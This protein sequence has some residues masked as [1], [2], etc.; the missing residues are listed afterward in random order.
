MEKTKTI[1]HILDAFAQDL[2]TGSKIIPAGSGELLFDEEAAAGKAKTK[3]T[4]STEAAETDP[5]KLRM[6]IFLFGTTAE[7]TSVRARIHGFQPFFFVRLPDSSAKTRSIFKNKLDSALEYKRK[8]L[9][10]VT[11]VT[12]EDRK[13][14][15]GYTGGKSFP[16]AR[17]TVPSMT[18]FRAL[19][20][21]FLT[22]DTS[23]PTFR[24]YADEDAL[25][26]Y[27]A[28]LDPMLRFFHLRNIKPCGWVETEIE[29]EEGG[30]DD[31]SMEWTEL[32][33]CNAPPMAAAPFLM[34]AWDIECYSE[35]GEF[36]LAKKGYDRLAKQIFAL[37]TDAG[38][39]AELILGAA[40]DPDSPP[41]GMDGLRHREGLKPEKLKMALESEVLQQQLEPLL[42]KREGLVGPAKEDRIQKI[43]G[44]LGG[45]LRTALPL[46]GD[47]VIQIGVVLVKG[48]AATEKHI[49]VLGT[50]DKVPGAIVHSY[51]TETKL[52]LGWAE[53]M[54]RWNPDILMGYNVFGFDEKYLWERATE[55]RIAESEQ[56]Q[57][58]S[59]LVDMEKKMTLETKFLSSSALGDNTMWMWSAFG[60]LQVDLFHYIKRSFSLPAY[61]LDYVCQHFMSGKLGGVDLSPGPA[62]Q[63]L[64]K[65]KTTGDAV[66]GR[67]VT[68]LDET[69]DAVVEKL[70]ICDI[71][72]KE[73]LVVEEPTGLEEDV[74]A[75][76][77][78]ALPD[79]VKWAVVKDDVSP[80]DIFRLHREG[81]PAGRAK[82]AA[83]C[84][85][86]CDLTV[87]LY[88]KLDVFNNAMA[89]ANACSVPVPYI[90]TRGQGIKIES[91]IFKECYEREQCVVVLPTQP[92]PV[93]G[94]E[95]EEEE[96]AAAQEES[97]EG[98]IVLTP[99]PGFYFK[100]PIGVADFASLYPSTIISENIS[101]DTLLWAKDYDL[102][103]RFIGYSYGSEGAGA[104]AVAWTDIEFDIWGNKEGDTRKHPEKVKKGL[105]VCRY[106]Q[107]VGDAKGTLPDIVQKL[108]AARKAKRKE[109]ERET[110][111]FKKA[112]LDAEQLAYKLTANSLYGQ[113]GSATFKIRL[114]HLAA[115]VTAYGRKQ[116]L[117]AKAAI[118]KFYGE[119]S[120]R[121]DC[122]AMT[123]YGDTDSLF[124]TFN[125][126]NPTTGELLTGRE[127]IVETMRL[128]EEAG[129][130]VT[131]CLKP[132]HDFEYDKVFAPFIIFSKKRYVGNKYEESPD[133]YYQNSMGIATKRR[134]YAGIV[135]VI[136]GGAIRI[137]LTEKD[138]VAAAN[139]VRGKL[140]DLAEGRTSTTQLTMTKS[141]RA[142]YKSPTP[143]AHKAL[144]DRITARDPGNA[145]A[146][147]DRISFLYILPPTGQQ[148]SKLQGDRVET[149]SYIKQKGLS[150][151]YKF[152]MEHQLMNPIAQLFALCVEDLPGCKAPGGRVWV[153]PAGSKAPV[154]DAADREYAAAE[155]LFREALNACDKAA[156]RRL[157]AK[158][159]GGGGGGAQATQATPGR[160]KI[161]T[162]PPPK[163]EAPKLKI[164]T[165]LNTF[166]VQAIL[167]QSMEKEMRAT[168]AKASAT[169]S[170]APATTPPET[171]KPKRG[172]K[173]SPTS[174]TKIVIEI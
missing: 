122:S 126:R 87:E 19:K 147:G 115:S 93:E 110:D 12:F 14:L 24:L 31:L 47:P 46:A 6:N 161:E 1:F 98:A 22:H 168:K 165:N 52:I 66:I 9:R 37:A 148:A 23:R 154:A 133:D 151:D 118:E 27:E 137:L 28:N 130:L 32:S 63:W 138:P 162:A 111:P 51:A 68:L 106:A 54:R 34:A 30:A 171:P 72:P 145:P 48:G 156:Q 5:S 96:G 50:C 94:A 124:I 134:D 102:E 140:M 155:Y 95:A 45:A 18:A 132:P 159:F 88:K 129:K 11:Q 174:A 53:A 55:L 135:K 105:R 39:A 99:T 117:F 21:F 157:A 43:R 166:A 97:Y 13:V 153:A 57:A 35:N 15:F 33:P 119:G 131:S 103:G 73:G 20:G 146:S 82:V 81:G 139:F 121:K 113:L 170:A 104:A 10:K 160:R 120:G 101:H 163:L 150:I 167:L 152:Y 41:K 108:L 59:R 112:L 136:Y 26:V 85:Q 91:L 49:F 164:Q 100:S 16:F 80:Q 60:R 144:A 172:R 62:G 70:R 42:E 17:L 149:P 128:T 127:A 79:A 169:A 77:K 8:W 44:L 125:V 38:H 114:Q 142:D 158:F 3:K 123:V 61:K 84:V 58:L 40:I 71:R 78:A 2:E 90:F 92:R 83:Y 173:K 109:A 143:P 25:E 56:M 64:L 69:G 86:D 76:L 74:L 116:I 141:L 67:Y 29:L 36:P 65:T 4:Q 7:G 75:D 89:M 107:F